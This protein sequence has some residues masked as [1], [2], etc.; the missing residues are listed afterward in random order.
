MIRYGP[1]RLIGLNEMVGAGL[2]VMAL[3]V[4]MVQQPGRL[5]LAYVAVA[6]LVAG[7]SGY[8]GYQLMR[9]TQRGLVLSLWLQGLQILNA[10]GPAF[11]ARLELGVKATLEVT[12]TGV[13]TRWGFGGM[14]GFWP[15][16]GAV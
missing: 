16:A 2:I 9:L 5:P 10:A 13:M 4:S 14:Y 15:W 3:G 12:R 6:M 11:D 8:A 7:V 1:H